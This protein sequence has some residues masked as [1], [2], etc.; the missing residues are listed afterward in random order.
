[1][2]VHTADDLSFDTLIADTDLAIVE[3]GARHCGPCRALEPIFARTADANRDVRFVKL[4][5]DDAPDLARRFGVRA[6]PT[7]VVLA[8]GKVVATRVGLMHPHQLQQLLDDARAAQGSS[9]A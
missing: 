8:C 2:S 5:V 6:M 7:I 4:D 1:M 9:A 3:L